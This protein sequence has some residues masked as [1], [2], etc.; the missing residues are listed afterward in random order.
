MPEEISNCSLAKIYV[1]TRI[2]KRETEDKALYREHYIYLS[3]LENKDPRDFERYNWLGNVYIYVA[4]DS[5]QTFN[6]IIRRPTKNSA[7]NTRRLIFTKQYSTAK[8]KTL[9]NDMHTPRRTFLSEVCPML[10]KAKNGNIRHT[11]LTINNSRISDRACCC[12]ISWLSRGRLK[13][14]R[15]STPIALKIDLQLNS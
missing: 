5:K 13:V 10:I 1:H 15:I 4:L 7:I 6:Y 8:P 12:S 9:F 14:S 11:S 3:R 2:F